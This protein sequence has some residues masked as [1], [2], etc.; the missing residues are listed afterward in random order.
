MDRV[1]IVAICVYA[2]TNVLQQKNC[3]EPDG[4]VDLH[5]TVKNDEHLENHQPVFKVQTV[6]SLE[7]RLK[8]VKGF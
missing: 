2:K 3:L 5:L 8:N 6:Q 1:A 7:V 4:M